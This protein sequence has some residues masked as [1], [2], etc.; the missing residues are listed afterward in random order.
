PV[1]RVLIA[2]EGVR[3][4]AAASRIALLARDRGVPLERPSR[5]TIDAVAAGA[6]HGGIVAEVGER[7]AVDLDELANASDPFVVLLDGI[8]DPYNF[9]AALRGLYAAGATG[10][11]LRT[12]NWLS[13]AAVVARASAGASELLPI[14]VVDEIASA[15][16]RLR[17]AG[18]RVACAAERPGALPIQ[19]V[20]LRAPLLL[21]IGGERRG[22][23][24]SLIAEADVLL[25]IPY[26]RKGAP[27]LGA[28]VAAAVIGFEVQR[29][30]AQG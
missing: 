6:S 3:D 11:V 18:L 16:R 17:G 12:R 1:H 5:Q 7:H 28:A 19:Q 4:A 21:L 29:Q 8:E 23:M 13:A 2:V 10:L 15:V 30:R 22:V 26:A 14:A 24:R 27:S 20:D 25:R 9:G